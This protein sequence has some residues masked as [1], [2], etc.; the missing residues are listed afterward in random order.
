MTEEKFKMEKFVSFM[1]IFLGLC[2]TALVYRGKTEGAFILL[3]ILM[4][5]YITF[6][7]IQGIYYPSS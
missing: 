5:I 7:L 1:I 2:I 3:G 4:V 6:V